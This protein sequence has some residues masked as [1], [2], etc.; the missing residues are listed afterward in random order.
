V[1]DLQVDDVG[2]PTARAAALLRERGELDVVVDDDRLTE[3]L[4]EQ[5]PDRQSDEVRHRQAGP[6]P[7]V[8]FDNARQSD[9]DRAEPSE[10]ERPGR[11]AAPGAERAGRG[12]QRPRDQREVGGSARRRFGVPDP[13][14]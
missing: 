9:T 4:R 3:L 11:R 14:S 8:R 6:Q 2:V 7:A 1:A 10:I 13:M 5:L 12:F